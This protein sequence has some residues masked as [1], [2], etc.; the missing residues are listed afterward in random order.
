MMR[1]A[2]ANEV[3]EAWRV[4]LKDTRPAAL[5]L[6]R[7]ALPTFDRAHMGA[8]G[9]VARGAYILREADGASP[10]VILIGT[11]SEVSLCVEAATH[12]AREGLQ[13]RVVSMP[14]WELFEDQDE[15]YRHMVLPPHIGARVSVEAAS[16][17]GWDRYAGPEGAK[18]GMTHFGASAPYK[19]LY[20]AF[21]FT[22]DNIA[23]LAKTQ[24][25]KH[26]ERI[27]EPSEIPA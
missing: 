23:A 10:D 2:D 13:A 26:K 22:A 19:D 21:G 8:A 7:Q 12:L 17:L 16:T 5:V 1:P 18:L 24:I 11:G 3:V 9:G 20:K 4:V 6:S 27:R 25:A 14:S 15:A